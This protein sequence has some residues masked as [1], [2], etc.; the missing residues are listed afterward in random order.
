MYLPVHDALL[1]IFDVEHGSCALL[2]CPVIDGCRRLMIDC[3]HN[4]SMSWYPGAHLGALGVDRLDEL[5]VTNY[6][7]DHVSGFQSF[8]QNEVAIG[9]IAR[10]A[11][12][13]PD[14]IL[15]LKRQ[16]GVGGGIRAFVNALPGYQPVPTNVLP[17]YPGVEVELFRN[18]Y[19]LFDDENNLSLVISLRVFGKHFLFPGDLEC[20]GFETLLSRSERFRYIVSTIDVLIAPHHGRESGICPSLFE[21]YQCR[22]RL[23]VIS[24]AL[25][26]YA[27]QQTVGYYA[28]KCSGI[29][30]FRK[31]GLRRVLT[32]RQDGEITFSFIGDRCVVN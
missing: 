8:A 28:G 20:E 4:A 14:E 25:K 3:G 30:G 9:C 29:E 13:A 12:I 32:T 15:Q 23:V 24:D 7:E 27:S 1:Q 31:P 22:P 26:Q 2:T 18:P 11:S 21:D 6:D 19:P 16:A 17:T 10:N 5:M